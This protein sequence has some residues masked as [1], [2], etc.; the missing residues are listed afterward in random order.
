MDS[1]CSRARAKARARSKIRT[2]GAAG[3][4]AC[5]EHSASAKSKSCAT[6]SKILPFWDTVIS[7]NKAPALRSIR[8]QSRACM[9]SASS[10]KLER[11][12]R[13]F[14]RRATCRSLTRFAA[15]FSWSRGLDSPPAASRRAVFG[16]LAEAGVSSFWSPFSSASSFSPFGRS[17]SP[18]GIGTSSSKPFCFSFCRSFSFATSASSATRLRLNSKALMAPPMAS[19]AERL[20]MVAVRERLSVS[21]REPRRRS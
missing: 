1:V 21:S 10:F 6:R 8:D 14:T 18:A 12:L 5:R 20:A 3:F 16:V 17:I 19:S 13:F 2:A 7:G 15:H 11:N 9:R 4:A